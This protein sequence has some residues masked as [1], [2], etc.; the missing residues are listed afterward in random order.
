MV[1]DSSQGE[2]VPHQQTTMDLLLRCEQSSDHQ[3]ALLSVAVDTGNSFLPVA[4]ASC[5]V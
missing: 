5:Q 4:A 2:V 1:T 3:T